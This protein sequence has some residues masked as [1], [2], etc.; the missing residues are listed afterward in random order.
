[1]GNIVSMSN[2]AG[3]TSAILDI[4]KENPRGM[5]VS[6]IADAIHVNR[7]TTARYMDGLLVS[8]RVEM[9][10]FGK[11]KVFF[12]SKRVPVSTML[13]LSS[14]MIIVTNQD[15]KVIQINDSALQF[16]SCTRDE[17]LGKSI[18]EGKG[19]LLCSGVLTTQIKAALCGEVLRSE[20]RLFKDNQEHIL[21]QRIHP[22]VLADGKPGVTIVLDDITTQV[23][24][25]IAMEQSE[26]MFRRL[27]ETVED[28][29]WSL[30]GNGIIQYMS[31]QI[32]RVTGYA[33]EEFVGKSF[34]MFMP[35]GAGKRFSW[36]LTTESS[37][38]YGFSLAEF[39]I[40]TKSGKT[41]YC[42]FTG[43]PV[44]LEE[45]KAIFLGY[46][47]AFRDVSGRR[48]A[49]LGEKRWRFFLDAVMENIPAMITVS[50][51]TTHRYFYVNR[52]TEKFLRIPRSELLHMTLVE[53]LQTIGAK[54]MQS[55]VEKAQANSTPASVSNDVVTI[56]RKNHKI[57]A[58]IV[59][60]TFT[61]DKKYLVSIV[62][63]DIDT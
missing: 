61:V 25:E 57:S 15:L 51:F 10:S 60:M 62:Y 23:N 48:E 50:D 32:Q 54:G 31:P 11:A 43:T 38:N 8:G 34:D 22:M 49:E 2:T 12:I 56:G 46:N 47:G 19:S 53:V 33:P 26:A 3:N 14:E 13:N 36:E 18:Y 17:V 29:I 5:S 39:P 40:H 16:L 35:D 4:L 20:I 42:D 1:M 45:D 55:A 24:A 59:P 58:K 37:Q 30:D 9:R 63:E 44:R 41:I 21:D 28:V 52:E 6:E 27:V 7:N